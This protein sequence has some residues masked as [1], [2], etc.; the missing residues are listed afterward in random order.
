MSHA[1]HWEGRL[2]KAMQLWRHMQT[3]AQLVEE[4]VQ[5]ADDVLHLQGENTPDLIH[6]HKVDIILDRGCTFA[7]WVSQSDI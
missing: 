6:K 3:K 2:Q 1:I 4:W 7:K 5:E